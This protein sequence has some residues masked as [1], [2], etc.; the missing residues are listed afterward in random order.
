MQR[1]ILLIAVGCV[2]NL[3]V[4]GVAEKKMVS[5]WNQTL[6]NGGK[7]IKAKCGFDMKLVLEG[8]SFLKSE[9]VADKSDPAGWCNQALDA[10][11]TLCEDKDYKE[12]IVQKV[13]TFKCS[14]GK[15]NDQ[16]YKLDKGTL[17]LSVGL[18][19]SN[20]NDNAKEFLKKNL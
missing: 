3:A 7:N 18:K 2:S 16:V 11:S 4:A 13:K 1:L 6:A 10:V 15:G 8:E 9:F 5:E 19:A 12:A 17:S 20:V 14:A